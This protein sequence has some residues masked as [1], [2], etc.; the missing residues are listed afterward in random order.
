VATT[1]ARTLQLLGLLQRRRWWPGSALA[2]RLGVSVRTLRRDVD[3]LRSLGYV[4][5]AT[6]GVD[7]GYRLEGGTADTPLLIDD[8]EAMAI[9]IGLRLAAQHSDELAEV[10]LGAVSKLHGALSPERRRR[11]EALVA[12][13]SVGRWSSSTSGP[14]LEVLGAVSQAC[15]DR[16]RLSFAYRAADG[17]DTDRYVEPCGVV[18]LGGR[19]YLVAF[20]PDRDDWRTFRLDRI[21]DPRPARNSFS[22]RAWP[23]ED[24]ATYVKRSI[25]AQ[26]G[27]RR[28]V[29]DV[30]APG[31]AVRARFG[32]WVDVT[33][34]DPHR[35][36]VTID[37]ASSDGVLQFV[38][39]LDAACVV[40]EPDELRERLAG[41]ATRL[42]AAVRSG[43]SSG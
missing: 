19:S 43:E 14:S 13:T 2:D 17:V 15:R 16:V 7:G 4:V 5:S 21:R 23:E 24:L 39:H 1:G 40:V 34:L 42:T 36:R 38:M 29:I 31:E 32:R 9:A 30:A 35:C 10:A 41:I 12:T 37:D 8:D 20:D 25:R 27:R 33:D 6:P 18:I 26:P 28:V 3:R 22:P 11:V